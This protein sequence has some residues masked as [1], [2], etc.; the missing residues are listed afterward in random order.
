M[1]DCTARAAE[2]NA[3]LDGELSPGDAASLARHV[4]ICPA[5]AAHLSELADLRARLAQLVAPQPAPAALRHVIETR[6]TPRRLPYQ[7]RRRWVWAGAGLALAASLVLIMFP[8]HN[9]ETKEFAAVRAAALRPD[10][11]ALAAPAPPAALSA[12]GFRL[13][14]SREDRVAGHSA[15]V[16]TY[17]AAGQSV[18]LCIWP[19]NGE[20]AHKPL[21]AHFRGAAITYWNNGT[22]EFWATS[23]GAT[24]VLGRFVR[25]YRD[26]P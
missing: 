9:H 7:W 4:A 18:T 22:N 23:F 1:T 17:V 8:R 19:A 13:V 11:A 25:A 16:Q 2:L 6:L 26:T 12:D 15:I 14:A 5:C 20:P 3:W 10:I 24:P 21:Q